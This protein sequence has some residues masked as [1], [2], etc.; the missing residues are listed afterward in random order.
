M[1]TLSSFTLFHVISNRLWLS[2]EHKGSLFTES[3]NCSFH[4]N[5]NHS[6]QRKSSYNKLKIAPLKW[7]V[8]GQIMTERKSFPKTWKWIPHQAINLVM[9]TLKL[10]FSWSKHVRVTYGEWNRSY[11]VNFGRCKNHIQHAGP[12]GN[13]TCGHGVGERY[14]QEPHVAEKPKD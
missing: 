7:Y 1:K 14:H 3:P 6:D 9:K 10:L 8:G 4:Y 13:N 2:V 12:A 11:L 5:E